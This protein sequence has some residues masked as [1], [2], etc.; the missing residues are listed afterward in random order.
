M[1]YLTKE[2]SR[3]SFKRFLENLDISEKEYE[4]IKEHLKENYGVKTYV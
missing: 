2:A 4:E 1:Y 3:N